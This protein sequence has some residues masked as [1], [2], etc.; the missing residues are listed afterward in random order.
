[1]GMA[2]DSARG[3]VVLFGGYDGTNPPGDTWT[4]DGNDWTER[5]PAHAPSPR[6]Q[7]G[8][9]YD[10][11]HS[12]VVLFGG[13]DNSGFLGDTWTWNGADWTVPRTPIRLMPKSGP[14]GAVVQ[15][16]AWG[17]GA[18]EEVVLSFIDSTNGTKK[19]ADLT[20]DLTGAFTVQVTIPANATLGA[21]QIRAKASPVGTSS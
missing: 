20:A 7:V 11:V 5:T 16:R 9:T 15:V 1:M 18:S 17:F 2:Y 8:M 13:L 19:L 4:W 10:T 14:P 12:R 6:Q 21:Q 3:Q